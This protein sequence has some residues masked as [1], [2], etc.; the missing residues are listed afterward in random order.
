MR[1]PHQITFYLVI[2]QGKRKEHM[3]DKPDGLPF[4]TGLDSTKSASRG[5]SRLAGPGGSTD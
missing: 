5:I 4:V 2:E 3:D 1:P